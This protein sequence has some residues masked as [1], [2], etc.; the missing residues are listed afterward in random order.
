[1]GP[2]Q[3]AEVGETQ[4]SRLPFLRVRSF[5]TAAAQRG[6]V[7]FAV[8]GRR[9]PGSPDASAAAAGKGRVVRRQAGRARGLASRLN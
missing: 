1:M 7:H 5:G 2:K 9:G 3:D 8:D 6:E 4:S